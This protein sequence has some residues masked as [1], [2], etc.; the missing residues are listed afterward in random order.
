MNQDKLEAV[1][2]EMARMNINIL[3]VSQ[4]K[5]TGTDEF[6]L[7]DYYITTVGKSPLEKME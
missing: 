7:D 6:N 2:Q 4:L 1:K 5:W 3:G